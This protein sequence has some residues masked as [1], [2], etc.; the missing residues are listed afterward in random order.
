M[1]VWL[2]FLFFVPV[3]AHAEE[4][5]VP[6]PVYQSRDVFIYDNRRVERLV[7]IEGE[8]VTWATLKGR[9]YV[10]SRNF[11]LPT[12]RWRTKRYSGVRRIYGNAGELWPL[13]EGKRVRYR[14]VSEKTDRKKSQVKRKSEFW[15]CDVEGFEILTVKA[16]MYGTHK[17]VCDRYSPSSMKLLKRKV[18]HYAPEIEHYIKY[19]VQSYITAKTEEYE[20]V[21]TLPRRKANP[22]RINQILASIKQ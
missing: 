20:L 14:V 4:P 7:S 9:E 6:P 15:R 11:F 12:L 17:I 5:P 8:E 10:R 18:W 13:E 21:A 2:L 16:G 19:Q 1:S 22:S 3:E